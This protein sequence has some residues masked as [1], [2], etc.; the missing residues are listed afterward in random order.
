MLARVEHAEIARAVTRAAYQ[1]GA[2]YVDV[3]Y[4]D[5]HLR[6]ALI[7]GAPDDVL[8]WTPPWLLERARRSATSAPRSSR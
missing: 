7:E 1:A 6:R 4:S 2:R 3:L 8:S 5:Q